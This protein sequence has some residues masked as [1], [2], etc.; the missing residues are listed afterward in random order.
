MGGNLYYSQAAGINQSNIV[1]LVL[2]GPP[3]QPKDLGWWESWCDC[4]W[5]VCA[6]VRVSGNTHAFQLMQAGFLDLF[7]LSLKSQ[8]STLKVFQD[9][10]P[11]PDGLC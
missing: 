2:I 8:K 10:S 6:H 5:C 3:P 7:Y 4:N 11:T 9:L 1:G